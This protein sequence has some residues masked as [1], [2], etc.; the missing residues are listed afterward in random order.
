[1]AYKWIASFFRREWRVCD[2]PVHT[3][4]NGNGIPPDTAW[5]A[6]IL[7]WPGPVGLGPTEEKAIEKLGS[8]LEIVRRRRQSMPRPGSYVPIQ[9][10][11]STRVNSDLALREEFLVKVLGFVP[12]SPVFI[13]DQSSLH[14]FGNAAHAAELCG[15]VLEVYGV[16]VSDLPDGLICDILERIK[17]RK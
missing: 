4:P 11:P 13:S 7:N 10:A 2:Y 3:R 5:I 12:G 15:K 1:M 16:D 17:R 14:D 9:F 6:Q 8:N